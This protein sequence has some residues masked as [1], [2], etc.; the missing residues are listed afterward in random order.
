LSA[1][2]TANTA[3]NIDRLISTEFYVAPG[4]SLS[5]YGDGFPAI[6]N[7][8]PGRSSEGAN[9]IRVAP[10]SSA[11]SFDSSLNINRSTWSNNLDIAT[12]CACPSTGNG[13]EA[14]AVGGQAGA[15]GRRKTLCL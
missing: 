7:Q 4:A 11:K 9:R 3:G 10:I 2:P 15:G 1:Q 12:V 13:G 14:V 8:A 6:P 5:S